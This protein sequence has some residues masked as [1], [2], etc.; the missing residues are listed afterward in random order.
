MKKIKKI[1]DKP[2]QFTLVRTVLVEKIQMLAKRIVKIK[3]CSPGCVYNYKNI[4]GEIITVSEMRSHNRNKKDKEFID[5]F[6]Y[7]FSEGGMI[8]KKDCEILH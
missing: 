5:N 2:E 8:S 3:S 1:S 4:I 6:E 7:F